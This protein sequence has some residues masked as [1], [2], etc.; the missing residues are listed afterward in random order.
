MSSNTYTPNRWVIVE[1]ANPN[2]TFRKVL[3][4]W[5]G[6]YLDAD[7]W[8]MSSPVV[9]IVEHADHWEVRNESGST[10]HCRRGGEG[11]TGLSAQIYANLQKQAE[12]KDDVTVRLIEMGDD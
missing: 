3:G 11:F 7:E 10:Y 2:E 1:I 12:T 6:G 8:R 9:E 5:S 4:G